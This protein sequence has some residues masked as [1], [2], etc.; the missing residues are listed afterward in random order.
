MS[1][2]NVNLL[3]RQ[4][5]ALSY[6]VHKSGPLIQTVRWIKPRFKP[7]AKSKMFRVRKPTPIDPEEH[8][9]LKFLNNVYKTHMRS[10]R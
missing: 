6:P 4:L 10:V 5:A 1:V 2:V 8:N 3:A 7:I 9:Q